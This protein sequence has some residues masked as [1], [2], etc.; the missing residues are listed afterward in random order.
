MEKRIYKAKEALSRMGAALWHGVFA[1]LLA[2]LVLMACDSFYMTVIF[3]MWLL[4]IVL[5][6]GVGF[7]LL[8]VILSVMG[9]LGATS[10]SA[11]KG[12]GGAKYEVELPQD[13]ERA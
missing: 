9:P 3:K 8:P 1:S 12:D 13:T 4:T 5:G 10:M 6:G 2:C 7:T 11:P